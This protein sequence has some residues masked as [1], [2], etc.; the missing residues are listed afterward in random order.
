MYKNYFV[1]ITVIVL[2]FFSLSVGSQN[3]NGL[4]T[5]I[6]E[7]KAKQ[8]EQVF[9]KI[10]LKTEKFYQLNIEGLKSALQ[11][12]G[13]RENIGNTIISFP[14]SDGKLNNFKVFEASIMEPELQAEYPNMRSYAG[15]GIDNPTEII[16]FSITDKG[17]HAM[18]LGT[19][20]GTQF[21]DPFS[22][23]G[24][25]YTVYSKRNLEARNFEF[26]CGVIDD[27]LLN[28]ATE[29]D[30]MWARNANDGTLRNYRIAVA[31]TGEYASYHGGTTAG[32]MAAIVVTMT[33]VNSVFERDLSIT[34]TLVANNSSIIYT[35]AATD[36]F[37]NNNPGILIGQSQTVINNIIGAANYDIGHTFS[38]GAGG[39]ASLGVTCINNFK[40][41]GVT[42]TD[43]PTSD[44]FDIDF[45]AH[46]LGHQFGA[47]HTF[48][49]TVGNCSGSNRSPAN[50]YEPGS[51]ST[52]MAYAGICGS[53]D[54][55]N[56]SDAYFHQNSIIRI[57]DHINTTGTCPINRTDTGNTEPI[58]NAGANYIIPKGTPYKLDGSNSTDVDGMESLTYTW[59]QYDLG[60]AGLPSETA[61]TG[62]LVR[63]YEGTSNP[64]RY[65]P[66][67]IDIMS[68]G[69]TSTT[70]EK[71]SNVNRN[72]N[73]KLT[74]RDNDA[75]GGQTGADQMTATV[76]AAAGPFKVTSQN[77]G[78][79][80][81]DVGSTQTIT[82]DV[83]GTTSNGIN[84]ANVNILLSTDGGANFNTVLAS[85]VPNN[86]SR[87]ITVP[88]VTSGSS[89]IM[90]EA[91]NG[92]FFNV[93]AQ[94]I[95][96]GVTIVCDTYASG[97]L[98]VVIPDSPGANVQGTPIFHSIN[99]PTSGS[100]SDM[101]VSLNVTH[102]YVGDLIVQLQHP[103]GSSFVNLWARTCNSAQYNNIDITFKDGEAAIACANPTA[104]T[105][106]PAN[107]LSAFDGLEM[108]GEWAIVLVDFYAGGTGTLNNWSLEFCTETMSVQDNEFDNLSIYPNPNNGQ[109]NIGFNSKSGE[110]VAI[111]VYDM[112]GRS[113]YN[114]TYNSVGRFE[115]VIQLDNA[116]SGV[117]M[118][119]IS[120]GLQK[121][122]KKIVVE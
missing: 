39:L 81:W 54:I 25:I 90:V 100:I 92:I 21:I 102:S 19:A 101:R 14:N 99:V 104:G 59:E 41:Q 51:G 48:N 66:R 56:G 71:L 38:T 12:V 76:A 113:I 108:S 95:A 37:N 44:A 58:A 70:W 29:D 103:N 3:S 57:W 8:S 74:V 33:R 87:A 115:E 16:R 46:E 55:Q 116:Q 43:Q 28:T 97:P 64:V 20:N 73:Y 31:C 84:E 10:E 68:N 89:R 85:N 61:L 5:A 11:N 83:A 91:A 112:R 30:S 15:Q 45:V 49:G 75:R 53:D 110:A 60:P 63:T 62:P 24:N 109:F 106:A 27:P 35:N 36:P 42:G 88:N 122:T 96:I 93:N 65:V 17:L 105:Y 119:T 69:G 82:W 120:D 18:F 86:G 52:I 1:R 117:Y 67:L 47:P 13:D 77:T 80:S 79:I 22:V 118:L 111:A 98:S 40:A 32:A 6:S 121:V 114:K 7:S 26:E 94:N 78:T 9:R 2:A 107:P 23:D 4:W 50:A 34:M 72:I